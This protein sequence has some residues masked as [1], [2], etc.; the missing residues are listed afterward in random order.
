MT[1][2]STR[3]NPIYLFKF[4]NQTTN[5]PYWFIA[6]DTSLYKQRYNQFTVTEIADLSPVNTLYGSIELGLQGLYDYEIYQTP[7]TTLD[8][9]N[10][11]LDAI[12]FI[13]LTVEVGIVDVVFADENY[14]KYQV[15]STTNIVYQ[16]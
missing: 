3:N 2:K 10:S 12:P 9:L 14:T 15:E 5:L 8:G 1:E 7:L 11:A 6:A 16:P 13:E 4:V